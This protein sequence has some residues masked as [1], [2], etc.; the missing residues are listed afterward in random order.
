MS[1]SYRLG[2]FPLLLVFLSF[3]CYIV[4][5]GGKA[6]K[7]D[8]PKL[9]APIWSPIWVQGPK[10]LWHHPML[11]RTSSRELEQKWS[12][13]D[14]NP[15]PYGVPVPVGGELA[16]LAMVA[17]LKWSI[18]WLLHLWFKR[19]SCLLASN[20]VSSGHSGPLGTEPVDG[21][22]LSILPSLSVVSLFQIKIHF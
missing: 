3:I 6:H 19:S 10:D 16:C 11:S 7:R 18:P 9:G 5:F 17:A 15:H 20:E 8:N 4:N 22:A 21:K 1:F 13:G 2:W 12:S 14:L